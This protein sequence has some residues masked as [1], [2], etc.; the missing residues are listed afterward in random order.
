MWCFIPLGTYRAL[1]TDKLESL[2]S[3]ETLHNGGCDFCG[4]KPRAKGLE[5]PF[6]V[7]TT[8]LPGLSFPMSDCCSVVMVSLELVLYKDSCCSESPSALRHLVPHCLHL[9]PRVPLQ[10]AALLNTFPEGQVSLG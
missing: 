3:G 2:T 6:D 9:L 1:K 10:V 8:E 5:W 4:W 7:G